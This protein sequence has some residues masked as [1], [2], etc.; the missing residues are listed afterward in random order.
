M[1][2]EQTVLV[3][4][5]DGFA[6][7]ETPTPA[8]ARS[9]MSAATTRCTSP[10]PSCRGPGRSGPAGS[11]MAASLALVAACAFALGN[12]MQQRGALR[13]SAPGESSRFL[14]QLLRHPVWGCPETRPRQASL[15]HG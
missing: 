1:A 8:I 9:S 7:I 11:G 3:V 4:E 6:V 12:A 10:P 14:L 15:H 2:V 5:A 13:T